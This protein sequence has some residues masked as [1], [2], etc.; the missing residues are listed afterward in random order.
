MGDFAH[1]QFF[2]R[3]DS[4][5]IPQYNPR[6]IS[7][8]SFKI[9]VSNSMGRFSLAWRILTNAAF[10]DNV[11]QLLSAAPTTKPTAEIPEKPA[12][13]V[14][15]KP[16]R[17]EAI[18]LLAALQRE[19]RFLDFLQEPLE[20]YTDAQV[21]AAVRDIHRDCKAVLERQFALRPVVQENEGEK[22]DLGA[23]PDP[24]MYK[25]SGSIS[26]QGVTRGTL[27]HHGWVATRCAVPVWN[28][29]PETSSIVAPAEIELDR[30]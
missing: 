13:P 14:P 11:T 21:G 5:D 8:T 20:Q 9:Q 26:E 23:N 12:I 19:G 28:G 15:P 3:H 7:I 10:S 1:Y 27:V 24:G 17:S 25:L 16:A 2:H 22:V 30:V 18:S 6:L 29:S 4:D